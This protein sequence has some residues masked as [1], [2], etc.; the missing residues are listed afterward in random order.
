MIDVNGYY[1]SWPY[2]KLRHGEIANILRLM[3]RWQIDQVL[4]CSTKAIFYDWEEGNEEV[5]RI[6][7]EHADRLIP[8]LTIN[9]VF[10]SDI[11]ETTKKYIQEGIKS[12]RV[13]PLYHRYSLSNGYILEKLT[14]AIDQQNIIVS[15]PIRLTMN[16]AMPVLNA[17]EVEALTEALEKN[18]IIISGINYGEL[19]SFLPL[20]RKRG[21]LFLET[22]CLQAR[23]SIECA[24]E[25]I[26]SDHIL[27]GTGLPIQ[28]PGI[29][30]AKQKKLNLSDEDKNKITG[31]N[32]RLLL[33]L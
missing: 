18:P 20:L 17:A 29:E 14:S 1:G 25:V 2:W 32:T 3:D 24:A 10:G 21:H 6:A 26:G 9:P 12:L 5:L 33:G 31:E 19:Y 7:S 16:W 23:G 30:I 8:S 11:R 4:I 27:M 13:F 15:V 22:S 28:N